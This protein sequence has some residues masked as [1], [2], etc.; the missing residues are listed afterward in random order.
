MSSTWQSIAKDGGVI[1]IR[2]AVSPLRHVKYDG[3]PCIA[4]ESYE[5][6][7]TKPLR[8]LQVFKDL[9]KEN[10]T[11]PRTDDQARTRLAL[12]LLSEPLPYSDRF[13]RSGWGILRLA[14]KY[15][16][17]LLLRTKSDLLLYHEY[18]SL[19]S[20][21]DSLVCV[22]IPLCEDRICRIREPSHPSILRRQGLV[23]TLLSRGFSVRVE[24]Y[25]LPVN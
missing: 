17:P 5:E 9:K 11:S 7:M 8:N 13:Y 10:G 14:K 16:F 2:S 12:G 3:N 22:P 24:R 15:G 20:V 23:K 18:L 19:L 25:S 1:P 6:D 21:A 4:V